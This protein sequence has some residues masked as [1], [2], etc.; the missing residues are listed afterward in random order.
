MGGNL[1]STLFISAFVSL[2]IMLPVFI[3]RSLIAVN[4]KKPGKA[5][6]M[7][8]AR[9]HV[10]TANLVKVQWSVPDNLDDVTDRYSV[11]VYEYVYRGRKYK[12]KNTCMEPPEEV[13]LYFINNPRHAGSEGELKIMN[14]NLLKTYLIVFAILFAVFY[15]SARGG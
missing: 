10:V 2:M 3:I 4:I 14:S 8:K 12:Y 7:A 11:G 15:L 6:E 5:V 9:G 1:V 13:T